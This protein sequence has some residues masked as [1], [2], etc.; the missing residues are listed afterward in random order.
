MCKFLVLCG[1][2]LC[3]S[4]T[5]AAQDSTAALDTNSSVSDP[6]APAALSPSD[7]DPWQL[8]AGFQYQQFNVLGVGFHNFGF[9][10]GI[11]RYLNDAFGLEGVAQMGFGHT[12]TG[13]GIPKRLDAKSLFIGGGPHVVWTNSSHV[14][15]WGHVLVGWEHFRFTQTGARGLGSNSTF[16]FQAGGGVDFRLGGHAYWRVQ[17]DYVGTHFNSAVQSSFSVGSGIVVGF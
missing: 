9:N 12:G 17:G 1:A 3:L 2:F 15:P 14:E 6:A 10:S 8:Q 4:L 5:A 7:R 16:G 13:P 11:V